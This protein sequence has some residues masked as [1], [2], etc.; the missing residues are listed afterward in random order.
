[1]YLIVC[2]IT[3]KF[4]GLISYKIICQINE[5]YN[6]YCESLQ[7]FEKCSNMENVFSILI[8]DVI[9]VYYAYQ[10]N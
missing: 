2:G 9:C 3:N 8:N 10:G 7:N 1:M 6:H 5:K 4:S